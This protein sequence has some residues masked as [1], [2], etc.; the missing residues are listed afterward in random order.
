MSVGRADGVGAVQDRKAV[1]ELARR[2]AVALTTYD[3]EHLDVQSLQ[4][5]AISSPAVVA[6]VRGASRDLVAAKASSV[7]DAIDS[8]PSA[9]TGSQADAFVGTSQVM[10]SRYQPAGTKLAGLLEMALSHTSQG[11]VVTDYRWLLASV[12]AP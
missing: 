2:F 12:A 1:A 10:T 11:W 4:L 5:S 3:Y 9:V 7:G 6:R 8:I